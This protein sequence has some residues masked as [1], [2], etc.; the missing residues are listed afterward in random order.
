MSVPQSFA[1]LPLEGAYQ[2]TLTIRHG[3]PPK[4]WMSP[5]G[6]EIKPRYDVDDLDGLDALDT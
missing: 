1:D 5:E 6:I 4:P 2:S 3:E